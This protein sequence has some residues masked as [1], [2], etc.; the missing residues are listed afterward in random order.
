VPS[1]YLADA[2]NTLPRVIRLAA[3]V[4]ISPV[5]TTFT[6]VSGSDMP[7]PGAAF[8]AIDLPMKDA[9]SDVRLDAGH[10]MLTAGGDKPVLDVT[11]LGRIGILDIV[12]IGST[13]G[14]AYRSG[15][16]QV[17]AMDKPILL[18]QGN[19]AVIG[20]KGLLSEINTADPGGR[21]V[22]GEES[23]AWLL[24]R[25]YWWMVPVLGVIFMVA[26][27]VFASRVRRRRASDA[28]AKP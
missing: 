22:V 28:A 13:S 18:A 12:T 23:G 7:A 27:L 11:G 14:V 2:V 26:L 24:S 9:R 1:A 19:V 21:A 8:L 4:G 20:D 16:A 6:A 5:K 15:G 10:L 25:G 17:P 3:T